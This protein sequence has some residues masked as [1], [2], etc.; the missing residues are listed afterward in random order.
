MVAV[1]KDLVLMRQIRTAAVDQIDT[2]QMVRLGNFLRAQMLFDGHWVISAAFD[3]RVVADDHALT[4]RNA[5]YSRYEASTGNFAIIQVASC[6]LADFQERR[7]A[8]QQA[9]DALTR[10][11]FST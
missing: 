10:Q 3:G 1:R 7:T 4:A 5:A 11:Q 9:F 2:W 6:K 8:I